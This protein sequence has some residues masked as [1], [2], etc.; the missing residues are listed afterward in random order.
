MIHDL[1]FIILIDP[2]YTAMFGHELTRQR[3]NLGKNT[4]KYNQ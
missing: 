1:F 4:K 3:L 2:N